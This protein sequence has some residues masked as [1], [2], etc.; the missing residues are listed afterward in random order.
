L[1]DKEQRPLK[2][3]LKNMDFANLDTNISRFKNSLLNDY[4]KRKGINR[5]QE[6][7]MFGHSISLPYPFNLIQLPNR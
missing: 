2:K 5:V 7:Q 3:L 4:K 6:G 1:D